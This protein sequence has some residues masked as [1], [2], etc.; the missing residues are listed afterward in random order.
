MLK[1]V[2]EV[3]FLAV[4]QANNALCHEELVPV[5]Q[6]N[7]MGSNIKIAREVDE[8][9]DNSSENVSEKEEESKN[10][11]SLFAHRMLLSTSLGT[12]AGVAGFAIYMSRKKAGSKEEKDEKVLDSKKN[13]N[14]DKSK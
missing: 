12:S 9:V 4:M 8:T 3:L 6:E 10:G 5:K 11:D 13:R 1:V 14:E 7:L 2:I